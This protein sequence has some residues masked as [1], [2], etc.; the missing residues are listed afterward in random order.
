[1]ELAKTKVK[2][3]DISHRGTEGTEREIEKR[4]TTGIVRRLWFKNGK[5]NPCGQCQLVNLILLKRIS[6]SQ[7]TQREHREEKERS[8][9]LFVISTPV[10]VSFV[11]VENFQPL[12]QPQPSLKRLGAR[13]SRPPTKRININ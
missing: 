3:E 10:V 9:R 1:M 4:R 12:Q 2:D 5:G 8:G 13:A 7:R 6:F 11:G